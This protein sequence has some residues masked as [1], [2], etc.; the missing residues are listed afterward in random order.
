MGKASVP[1]PVRARKE[2]VAMKKREWQRVARTERYSLFQAVEEPHVFSVRWKRPN[3]SRA[4]RV[5]SAL[6]LEN[7]FAQAPIVSGFETAQHEEQVLLEDAFNGALAESRR[8]ERSRVDW[9]KSCKRFAVWL[10]SKHPEAEC[11]NQLTRQMLREYLSTFDGKSATTRRLAVQPIIQTDGFMA[12]EYGTRRI[13]EFLKIGGTPVAEPAKV[14]LVD[15]ADFCDWTRQHVAE[16]EVGVALQG[17]AGLRLQEATR[18]VHGK[19][20][21]N[22]GLVEVSGE[23]KNR[24]SERVIPVC[25][26]VQEALDRSL[27]APVQSVDGRFIPMHHHNYGKLVSR[28]IRKWNPKVTWKHKDL[29]NALPTFAASQGVLSD[30]W[31]QY[32][33]HAPKTVT[34]RHYLPRLASATAGEEAELDRQ[35]VLFK[36]LVIGPLEAGM[37]NEA[38]HLFSPERVSVDG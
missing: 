31:E 5:F 29:R 23:V 16:I 15:V 35:M 32:L 38:V 33:G 19:V 36:R 3:G 18:L 37:R 10:V 21:L 6:S 28:A 4:Y 25:Q 26:R 20:D 14:Y 1:P 13:A 30:L 34:A 27:R 11:W 9:K 24:W 7:A 17:L 22:R 2:A 12:R 8:N